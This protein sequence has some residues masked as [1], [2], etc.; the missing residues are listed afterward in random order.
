MDLI[1]HSEKSFNSAPVERVKPPQDKTPAAELTFYTISTQPQLRTRTQRAILFSRRA[2]RTHTQRVW[3]VGNLAASSGGN[4]FILL[5]TFFFIS[6]PSGGI[7]I[8]AGHEVIAECAYACER[9][10]SMY[11]G[12]TH[13]RWTRWC[14]F[15]VVR[16]FVL[17]TDGRCCRAIIT[18]KF[19]S[20]AAV[21]AQTGRSFK[22]RQLAAAAVEVRFMTQSIYSTRPCPAPPLLQI[23]WRCCSLAW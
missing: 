3:K 10:Y 12:S 2:H 15:T 19:E 1:V 23:C 5:Q 16:L 11:V 17:C 9:T 22:Q 20:A 8:C 18:A 4:V 21:T 6:Q 14:G 7:M 13:C